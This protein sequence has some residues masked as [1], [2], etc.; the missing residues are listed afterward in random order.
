MHRA[1]RLLQG[2]GA[3]LQLHGLLLQKI[4]A[5]VDPDIAQG[6]GA[7][8]QA[9]HFVH[10]TRE[11]HLLCRI[12]FR[13]KVPRACVRMRI[14]ATDAR[15]QEKCPGRTGVEEA[16]V[17]AGDHHRDCAR[18]SDPPLQHLDLGKVQVIGWFIE[19]QRIRFGDPDA[20]K[21][22]QP[23]PT[24]AQR[25]KRTIMQ[26]GWCAEFVEHDF[27]TPCLGISLHWRN[28]TANGLGKRQVEKTGRN[29]LFDIAHTHAA[30][31]G[32]SASGRFHGAGQTF[33]QRSFATT[34]SGD[35]TDTIGLADHHAEVLEQRTRREYA[36]IAQADRRHCGHPDLTHR[37]T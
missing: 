30:R 25:A 28:G 19:Q 33:E 16:A 26:V 14:G 9:V 12:V 15:P 17:M 18:A 20:C 6:T 27:D 11:L 8:S 1:Q 36:D 4:A 24:A 22:C 37:K 13:Q 7:V 34:V 23:L 2:F 31:A 21:Q 10:I 3:L 32:D 35:Q 5:A 29:I